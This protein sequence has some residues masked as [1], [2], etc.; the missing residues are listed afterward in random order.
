MSTSKSPFEFS[1][2]NLPFALETSPLILTP[3]EPVFL[4]VVL[5]FQAKFLTIPLEPDFAPTEVPVADVIV[6]VPLAAEN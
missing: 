3:F 4:I 2:S 1:T 6:I 5:L